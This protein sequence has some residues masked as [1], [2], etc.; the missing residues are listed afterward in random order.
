MRS[1]G[2][3]SVGSVEN[4]VSAA[5]VATVANV[6]NVANIGSRVSSTLRPFAF[7]WV[8]AGLLLGGCQFFSFLPWVDAPEEKDE[9]KDEPAEL[10]DFEAEAEFDRLWR[11]KVG[12]GLGRKYVRL[13]P[14]VLADRLY[15]ADAYGHVAAL[16]RFSGKEIWSVT[17]GEPDDGPFY[18]F[19]DRRDPSFVTGGVGAGD[20]RILL[21][22][23]RGEVIAL[24][25]GDGSE[26]WRARV[27]S[28]VL[29]PPAAGADVVV[30]QTAD[31]NLVAL[32]AADGSQRWVFNSQIPLL[33]LRG[34]ATPRIEGGL[35]FVGFSDGNVTA[36]NE[37]D[38]APL[39]KQRIMLPQGRT[40]LDRM[41]DV[42]ST[43]F[44]GATGL[45]YAASF[46]GRLKALRPSD[47]GMVWEIEAST[48]L[49]L[50][51]G[52]GQ[53]Y[54]VAT[55]DVVA[56]VGQTSG[57]VAWRQEALRNRSLTSPLAFGNHLLVGDA[58]G[59]L[60]ALAQSDGRFLA[61]RKIGNGLRSPL[62]HVDGTVYVLANDGNVEALAIKRRS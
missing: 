36:V 53:V 35:V 62:L 16:D 32:E 56:A 59:Y 3:E 34:T 55:D 41:V 39:W 27:A 49:D 40:E 9:D 24:D 10:V 25:A 22:T 33:T 44:I 31:G 45:L 26:L 38:G 21:G 58:D 13:T 20:G 15:V 18:E 14:A 46:Q 51:E 37:A 52:Y 19:W 61:R 42:D 6:A 29:S 30:A 8:F 5:H 4:G 57:T 48:Y 1:V 23:V 28:E 11:T 2:N 12:R 54:F 7:A 43:P 60:H 17:V 47:G 50:A